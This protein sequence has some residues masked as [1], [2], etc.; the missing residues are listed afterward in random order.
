MLAQEALTANAAGGGGGGPQ[1]HSSSH[2]SARDVI[3]WHKDQLHLKPARANLARVTHYCILIQMLLAAAA[4][5]V[6]YIQGPG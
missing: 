5:A 3:C 4:N 2:A 6:A 1:P